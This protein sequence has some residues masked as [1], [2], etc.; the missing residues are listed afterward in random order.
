MLLAVLF[1][2]ADRAISYGLRELLVRSQARYSMLYR[3]GNSADVIVVGNSRG[4]N[5]FYA[6]ILEKEL[7]ARVVNLSYNALSPLIGEALIR[8]WVEQNG[9]PRMIVVE[10][11]NVVEKRSDILGLAPYWSFSERLTAIAKRETPWQL[12]GTK[13]SHLLAFNSELFLRT[14]YYLRRSD[15]DWVNRYRIAPSLIEETRHMGPITFETYGDNLAVLQRIVAY[16]RE[17]HIAVRFVV[18]PYLPDYRDHI[19]NYNS[20]LERIESVAGTK[21]WD[22]SRTETDPAHFADRLHLNFQ[23]AES[24]AMSLVSDGFF[25]SR[26]ETPMLTGSQ[27]MGSRK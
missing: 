22:L 12:W 18:S 11:S 8:D 14:L 13:A 5:G 10:V 23:G 6:P 9:K 17:S 16:C 2:V 3:G 19:Q 21:V 25:D 27:L 1:F 24:L 7:H 15:Q 20:W 4:V 26:Q